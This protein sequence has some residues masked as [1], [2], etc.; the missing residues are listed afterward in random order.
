MSGD[1]HT[2]NS[3]TPDASYAAW[4]GAGYRFVADLADPQAGWWSVEVGSASGNPGSSHYGDQLE[5]WGS[6]QLVYNSLRGEAA[7]RKLTLTPSN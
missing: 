4:I 7:G 3:S 6:G 1:G 5:I 2:V